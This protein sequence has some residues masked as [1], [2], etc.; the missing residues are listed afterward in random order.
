LRISECK[1]A[2]DRSQKPE[3]SDCGFRIS[4]CGM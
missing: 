3:V 1:K 2:E 4:D